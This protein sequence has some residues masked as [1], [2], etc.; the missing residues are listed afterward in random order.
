MVQDDNGLTISQVAEQIGKS[1]RQVR[2]YILDGSL[3]A[4]MI[5]GKYGQEYRIDEIPESLYR[6]ER[7]MAAET[8][9]AEKPQGNTQIAEALLDSIEAIYEKKITALEAV[10]M[11][12][13]RELGKSQAKVEELE[14]RLKLLP[15][16]SA[17]HRRPLL[18]VIWQKL[19]R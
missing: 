10:N 5:D 16:P 8:P 18:K 15:A 19:V 9:T 11:N 14:S 12:L 6:K 2:R 4:R 13:A 7:P 3:P 1:A 17:A